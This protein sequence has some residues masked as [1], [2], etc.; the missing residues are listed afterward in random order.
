VI[1]DVAVIVDVGP[2]A[3]DVVVLREIGAVD[4]SSAERRDT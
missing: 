1:V 2:L 3:A 4:A